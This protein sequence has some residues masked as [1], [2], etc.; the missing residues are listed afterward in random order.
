MFDGR[1]RIVLD[2]DLMRHPHSGLYHYCL[3]LGNGLADLLHDD[4][5]LRISFFLPPSALQAF[6]RSHHRVRDRR[7]LF[8]LF[9][10]RHP[11][12]DIWHAPFQSG[13]IVPDVRKHKQT[14]IV[15]T[16]H[17][18][19]A[20]HEGKPREEQ[21]RSLAHTQ[22]LIDRA[23]A[24]V[25]IS[26]FCRQD[27]Y[28]HCRVDGKPVYVI[29]NGT[30]R[31]EQPRLGPDSYRPERPFLFSIGYVN[32]KKNQGVLLPLLRDPN[33]ELVIAGRLDEPDYVTA[34][35]EQADRLG[36]SERL[37]ITGPVTESEK[38]WYYEHCLA[39]LHPSLAEGFGAPVAEIMQFGK[40]I[41]LADRTALPEIGGDVAFYFRD[42]DGDR[43][44]QVFR[45]GMKAWA[46]KG[47]AE[48][49]R[50]RGQAFQWKRNV[51]QYLQVYRMLLQI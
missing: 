31:V 36:V 47:M 15:L 25:C 29:H 45:A 20:L 22:G 35:R 19:N 8:G 41:F 51:Q 11:R 30:H 38:A 46:D 24:I 39:L 4:P 13:R 10:A 6:P 28:R 3:N 37:R 9:P 33:L 50:Q 23:D 21:E 18:L 44:Q 2:C 42:F 27:V 14:R 7:R 26:E 12:A 43:M 34:I 32:R 49:I 17:D 48:K 1:K 5:Q 40:P 16:V